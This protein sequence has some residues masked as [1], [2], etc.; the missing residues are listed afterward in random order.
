MADSISTANLRAKL[1]SSQLWM[2]AQDEI[3]FQKFLSKLQPTMD[4]VK[5]NAFNNLVVLNEDLLPAGR[6]G[7]G[8]QITL[9]LMTKLTGAGVTGDSKL[10]DS[11]ESVN[12]YDFT[13]EVEQYR[14]AVINTGILDDL[15]MTFDFRAGCRANL[16]M[17]LAELMD[18]HLFTAF[19]NS[20]T[21]S[22]TSASN[23]HLYAAA[24]STVAGLDDSTKDTGDLF[25]IRMIS[26]ARRLAELSSPRIR[27]IMYKGKAYFVMLVHPYQM[28]SLRDSTAWKAD[29]QNAAERGY[30]NPIFSGAECIIDGVVIH[31]HKNIKTAAIG[32]ELANDSASGDNTATAAVARALFLGAQAGTYAVAKRPFWVEDD[33]DYKNQWGIATGVV[34]KAAKV[35]WNSIDY[36]TICCDTMIVED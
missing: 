4:K 34:Y 3:F 1:W 20:P 22:A 25:D 24:Q 30:D 2:E 17:W 5:S 27:P 32:E 23:R 36:A 26:K 28:K 7:K 8:Y 16:A 21:Y 31:S 29:Y 14:N 33:D 18:G 15:K 35:V 13:V 12:T 9:P 19:A 10:K 11:E 6:K